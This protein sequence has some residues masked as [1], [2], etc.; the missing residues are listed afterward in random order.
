MTSDLLI[1]ASETAT[2]SS[3]GR[4]VM[5]HL[6]VF[7]NVLATQN[8][9]SLGNSSTLGLAHCSKTGGIWSLP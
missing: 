8:K 5:I 7:M 3:T 4:M 9:V 1:N 2:A 6:Q